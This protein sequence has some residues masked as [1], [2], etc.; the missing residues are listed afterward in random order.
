MKQL[1][2]KSQQYDVYMF[3]SFTPIQYYRGDDTHNT[4]T[5]NN[6]LESERERKEIIKCN[7]DPL[8]L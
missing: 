1:V 6:N 5:Q 8:C 2:E 3:I 4:F 7:S